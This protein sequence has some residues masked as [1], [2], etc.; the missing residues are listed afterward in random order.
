MGNSYS[1]TSAAG[2]PESGPKIIIA[3]RNSGRFNSSYHTEVLAENVFQ[4][5]LTLERRRAERSRK[6]FVLMLFDA[7]MENGPAEAILRRAVDVVVASKRETDLVGWYKHGAIL[8]IIFTEV[9]MD[10]D[11]PVTETLRAKMEAAFVEHMGRERADAIAISLHIF[12][13]NQGKNGSRSPQ[14][15]RRDLAIDRKIS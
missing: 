2:Q 5:M 8:G 7:N 6:P 9:S 14:D 1:K 15:S 4:S 10:G 11:L 13:E 12:P 3:P